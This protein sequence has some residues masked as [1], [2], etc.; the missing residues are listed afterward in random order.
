M[1]LGPNPD[2]SWADSDLV[3]CSRPIGRSLVSAFVAG[4]RQS[5][6]KYQQRKILIIG[7]Y[8]DF[9]DNYS[10]VR[11]NDGMIRL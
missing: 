1:S 6:A 9:V 2:K 7:D 3:V 11:R 5:V 4:S 10:S 8:R